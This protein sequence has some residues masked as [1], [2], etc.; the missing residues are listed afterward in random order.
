MRR[1]ISILLLCFPALACA[2]A[3]TAEGR[4]EGPLPIPGRELRLVVDLVPDGAG[5]WTGS[6]II[7]GLGIKGAPLSNLVVTDS[8]LTF[9][10][11]DLLRSPAFGPATFKAHLSAVDAMAG[12]MSQGGNVASFALKRMGPPQVEL[13]PRSPVVGRELEGRWIGDYEMGGYPRHVTIT[14]ENHAD[15]GATA[16]FVIVGKQTNNLPVDRVIV[17]G[18]FLRIESRTTRVA[19]EGRIVK[20]RDEIIGVVELGGVEPPLVLHRAAAGTP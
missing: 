6:I 18:N 14:L 20:D 19:F 12:D 16:R 4:W 13:P 2:A 3:K 7:S 5:I 10:L 15:A 17:D 11:G 1:T 9:D 8:D